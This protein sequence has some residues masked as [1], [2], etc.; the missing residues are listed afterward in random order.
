MMDGFLRNVNEGYDD[1]MKQVKENERKGINTN[2]K[3][4]VGEKRKPGASSIAGT[5]Q[6]RGVITSG[7]PGACKKRIKSM[8]H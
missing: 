4:M 1:V 8:R 2:T 6:D 3:E 5:L 7:K